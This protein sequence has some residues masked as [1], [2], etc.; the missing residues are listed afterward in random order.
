MKARDEFKS[1]VIEALQ[2]IHDNYFDGIIKQIEKENIGDIR[3]LYIHLNCCE[4]CGNP[5]THRDITGSLC[6]GCSNYIDKTGK[7]YD[8]VAGYDV[9]RYLNILNRY[10]KEEMLVLYNE[11]YEFIYNEVI[12]VPLFDD[13]EDPGICR[14]LFIWPTNTLLSEI[15]Q[16]FEKHYPAVFENLK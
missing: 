11:D 8:F 12:N 2:S 4:L 3:L 7:V 13:E 5:E 9:E 6:A 15:T 10:L 16:W 1:Y 14:D